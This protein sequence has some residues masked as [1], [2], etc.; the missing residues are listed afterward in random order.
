ML[1]HFKN[2]L[3]VLLD[4]FEEQKYLVAVSGGMDSV[5]L[6]HLCHEANLDFAI[7][8]VNYHLRGEDSKLDEKFVRQLG[9]SLGV[10]VH[11]EQM[12]LSSFEGNI[13]LEA[14]N[15]RY[16]FFADL[17]KSN[18]YQKI[19]T[20]HHLDDVAETYLFNLGRGTGVAGL[21]GIPSVNG[22]IIRPMIG[23]E[24][25][26]IIEYV[27]KNKMA[28][29]EDSSNAT[30]KYARNFLRHQVIPKLKEQN[31]N[32]LKGV[33]KSIAH[34]TANNHF[35]SVAMTYTLYKGL[36][37]ESNE[38]I[39]L[40]ADTILQ[41]PYSIDLA[42]YWLSP[43][44]F[45]AGQVTDFFNN[46]SW[47]NGAQIHSADWCL[48]Y[49]RSNLVLSKLKSNRTSKIIFD[50]KQIKHITFN[51]YAF[52][53]SFVNKLE[54]KSDQKSVAYF[55]AEQISNL[56]IKYWESGDQ[57]QPTGMNGKSK[58]VKKYFTDEK[59][60]LDQKKNI[61]I[62][63]AG[64]DIMWIVGYRRDQRFEPK[65]SSATLLKIEATKII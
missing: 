5:L 19:M 25:A 33:Q 49:D 31:P 16:S 38:R 43:F 9:N 55:D 48:L 34:Q 45:S 53:F 2:Q 11:V 36:V 50:P 21:L 35:A 42:Y 22:N 12:D 1:S 44:G 40:K 59:I 20:A 58:S 17:V 65:T 3:S 37:S 54:Q 18:G 56:H 46:P 57:F 51:D 52:K 26:A 24:K 15:G 63:F 30:D 27:E 60:A 47:V 23:F 6:A 64:Q 32:F 10:L 62:V 61:P 39:V 14:R 7:C 4:S 13:Q 8:H 29:R 28:Y 41:S